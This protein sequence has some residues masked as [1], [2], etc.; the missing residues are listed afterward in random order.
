MLQFLDTL[1]QGIAVNTQPGSG[2]NG[3][4]TFL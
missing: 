4:A 1:V 3:I 2:L